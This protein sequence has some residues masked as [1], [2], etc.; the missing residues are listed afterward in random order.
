M[1]AHSL[2]ATSS[3]SIIA[4]TWVPFV[5]AGPPSRVIEV[6]PE[7]MV[8]TIASHIDDQTPRLSA[9]DSPDFGAGVI[10]A[11][12]NNGV[13]TFRLVRPDGVISV[14]ATFYDPR[15][16][17]VI[18]V[19]HDSAGIIDGALHATLLLQEGGPEVVTAYVTIDAYGHVVEHWRSG[20]EFDQLWYDFAFTTGAAGWPAGVLLLDV[21]GTGGTK[22]A[23]MDPSFAVTVVDTDSIPPDR[24]DTD[25][26]GL[27][28][29]L[30]GLYG[31]GVLLADSDL[32]T[33]H[34]TALYE[35]RHPDTGGYRLIGEE[36][37]TD[38]RFYNDLAV[39]PGGDLGS[40]VY[41]TETLTGEVQ[42]VDPDGNH[43][44]WATGFV[45]V[46]SLSIAPD[47]NSMYVSDWNG[48]HLIRGA[49]TEP[50][51]I[52]F[53]HDPSTPPGSQ[54]TGV[55][56][57]AVR[58]VFSEPVAF[59]DADVIIENGIGEPVGFDAS[60]S[61]SQFML[62]GLAQ[63]LLNDTYV[64]TVADTVVSVATG[65][66]LDGDGDGLAGG[67]YIFELHHRNCCADCDD[68]GDTD[69]ADFFEF[70][71]LFTGPLP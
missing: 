23:S 20:D 33:D 46:C 12:A 28:R 62:I 50:G 40:T 30:T 44:S 42:Q 47:G 43:T 8:T 54:L 66:P 55:P 3:I 37:S 53:C 38:E 26:R 6:P 57:G 65:Q 31:G 59:A 27:Q 25:V 13:A 24:T 58:I 18:R 7:F 19:R 15:L 68:D 4:A 52:V 56:A 1:S 69:L 5:I 71:A 60:G 11:S 21:D 45:G 51:P 48:V 10:T 41:V 61:G 35:L 2:V 64:I 49:V 70:Q 39:S 67:N 32:N 17:S 16:S 29:D 22:L 63:P 9:I 36:V 14:L 34:I